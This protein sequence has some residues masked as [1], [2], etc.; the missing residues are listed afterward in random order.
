MHYAPPSNYHTYWQ[1]VRTDLSD[2]TEIYA[3][4]EYEIQNLL[5]Y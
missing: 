2:V 4:T 1:Q 3:F 5:N